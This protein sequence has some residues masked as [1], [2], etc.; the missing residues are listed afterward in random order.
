[1]QAISTIMIPLDGS[2]LAEEALAYGQKVAERAGARLHLVRVV[3]PESSTTT[4]RLAK[5]YLERVPAHGSVP[6]TS[7]V[8][9]GDPA[10]QILAAAAQLPNP[11]IVMTTHGRSGMGRWLI[12]SV[13]DRVVRGGEAPVLVLRSGVERPHPAT[14]HDVIVPLDGSPLAERAL[15]LAETLAQLLA[16]KLTLVRV[17]DTTELLSGI[18]MAVA[19]LSAD[20]LEQL[21]RDMTDD[22]AHY[23]EPLAGQVRVDG[24]EVG[25]AALAGVPTDQLLGQMR[26]MPSAMVVMATHGRGGVRRLVL[27]SVAERLLRLGQTPIVMVPVLDA[28]QNANA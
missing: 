8:R 1:M 17:A 13:A 5:D 26:Q 27:G 3:A 19:P 28:G 24:V 18:G 23:L 22:T 6:A 7:E 14:V 21:I 11:M 15:P 2:P 12:G 9:I 10:D 25:T 20:V 4:D 16:A